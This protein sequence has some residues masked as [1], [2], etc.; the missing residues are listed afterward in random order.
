MDR[1]TTTMLKQALALA[2]GG[3]TVLVIGRDLD[4]CRRL[5]N[6]TI[7]LDE[8]KVI[9]FAKPNPANHEISLWPK[10]QIRYK[11]ATDRDWQPKLRQFKGYPNSVPTLVAPE[12]RK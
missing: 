4:H 1:W 9:D 7:Y 8:Y 5:M 6:A 3:A 11:P 10:G 2:M 12:E